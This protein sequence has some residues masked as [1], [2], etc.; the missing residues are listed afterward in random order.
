[1]CYEG[2]SIVLR[3][4][5]YASQVNLLKFP[6]GVTGYVKREIQHIWPVQIPKTPSWMFPFKTF[7]KNHHQCPKKIER[8]KDGKKKAG[9]KESFTVKKSIFLP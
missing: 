9:F 4:M 3:K 2:V 8:Q 1:M 6:E 5:T 7:H